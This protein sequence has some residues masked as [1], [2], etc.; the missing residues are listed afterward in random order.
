M[1][2]GSL[3]LGEGGSHTNEGAEGSGQVPTPGLRQLRVC[4][5]VNKGLACDL[6]HPTSSGPTSR[7]Y[8]AQGYIP[9]EDVATV[10]RGR[11]G[12]SRKQ[13]QAC[14]PE[15]HGDQ[16]PEMPL[17]GVGAGMKETCWTSL[18]S[19]HSQQGPGLAQPGDWA[20]ISGGL[21]ASGEMDRVG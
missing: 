4:S 1:V 10:A 19:P 6:A 3:G 15:H 14:G 20:Q 11:S 2:P 8:Q 12:R 7:P 13:A 21:Q 16:F 5:P 9:R 17:P 18:P